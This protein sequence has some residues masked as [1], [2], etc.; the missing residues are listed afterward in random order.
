MAAG[1]DG[2]VSRKA[3][4]KSRRL[5]GVVAGLAPWWE[6]YDTLVRRVNTFVMMGLA[7]RPLETTFVLHLSPY[8]AERT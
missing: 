3:A 5:S 6:H 7:A 8:V 1:C 2:G 4:W